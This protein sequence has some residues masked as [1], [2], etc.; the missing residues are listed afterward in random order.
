MPSGAAL[1]S[2]LPSAS[3]EFDREVESRSLQADQTRTNPEDLIGGR[4]V[5][6]QI[7][8]AL[9]TPFRRNFA[10]RCCWWMRRN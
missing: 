9:S 5:G 10:R 2:S 8:V 1:A 4:I 6:S 7:E 3:E